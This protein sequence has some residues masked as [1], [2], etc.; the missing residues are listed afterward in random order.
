MTAARAR[1]AIAALAG[2][3]RVAVA[4]AAGAAAAAALPPVHAVPVLLL[5]VPVFLWLL[6]APARRP[7]RAAFLIGWLFGTGFFAAG[8]YW[9]THSLLVEADRFWWLVPLAVPVLAAGLGLFF[10]FAALAATATTPAGSVARPVALAVAWTI[11][12]WL[13]GWVLTGFPWNL[14]ATAW[15]GTE[16]MMQ[17][18]AWIG[19]YGLSLVTILA[20]GLAALVADSRPMARRA[21]PVLALGL[22]VALW[23]AGAARLALSPDAT[24]ASVQLRIVQGNV[25]QAEKWDLALRETHLANYLRRST[26][27]PVDGAPSPTH[28]IWPETAV[29]YFLET[30]RARR[31]QVAAVAPP[32]GA[33]LTGAVRLRRQP[34]FQA[35]NSLLVIDGTGD[36]AAVYDKAHLV[37]FGEYVPLRGVLPVE[38]IAQGQGDFTSGPGP[39]T[40]TVPGLP[41]FSPLICYEVIFPGKVVAAGEM[42][43][44]WLL[45]VT[46]DAWFGDSAGPYQ[47]LAAAQLRAVEEGLPLIRAANTGIS[48]VIDGH[49]RVRARLGINAG[50]VIDHPL[51][52]ALTPTPFARWGNATA[53]LA[54]L[55]VG[56]CGLLA[57]RRERQQRPG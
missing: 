53:A 39:R 41:P 47:H 45:N 9:I 14:I 44:R 46:N 19:A 5:S 1:A 54:I 8:L 37:P 3:R 36:V 26:A 56:T 13:R 38:R 40:L 2:W 23:A 28:V 31:A 15:T 10:G 43:P 25:P 16:A 55:L 4:V 52:E 35:W 49:G 33:V 18:A 51:P 57:R 27:P 7:L 22:L 42:R 48:A 30:D 11:A 17:S 20:A 21:G 6:E 32:G 34:A 24:V 12:E 29:P 50:G